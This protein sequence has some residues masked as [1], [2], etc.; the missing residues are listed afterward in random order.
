MPGIEATISDVMPFNQT[1]TLKIG[2]H[3]VIL[4]FA[5]VHSLYG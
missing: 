2:D 5:A 1:L 3:P 4:G